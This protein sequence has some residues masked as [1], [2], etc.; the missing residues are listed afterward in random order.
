MCG[1][2]K[3]KKKKRH[4][5]EEDNVRILQEMAKWKVGDPRHLK[6]STYKSR[7]KTRKVRTNILSRASTERRKSMVSHPESGEKRKE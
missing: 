6:I 3:E 2:S 1:V 7:R 4:R 5:F